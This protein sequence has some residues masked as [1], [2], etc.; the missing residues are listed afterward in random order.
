MT[1]QNF[2]E[3][4]KCRK[5]LKV[6]KTFGIIE[7]MGNLDKGLRCVSDM[8]EENFEKLVKLV[9]D[10]DGFVSIRELNAIIYLN[11]KF[12]K[13]F[14][15]DIDDFDFHSGDGGDNREIEW[16][17]AALELD[18][19]LTT[20]ASVY[21]TEQG[22]MLSEELSDINF[23][24]FKNEMLGIERRLWP[25]A[26]L[27]LYTNDYYTSKQKEKRKE[28]S[29]YVLNKYG[30]SETDVTTVEHFLHRDTK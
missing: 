22:R 11:S 19:L 25:A 15:Y 8:G 16:D 28:I 3:K 6:L 12:K 29:R 7:R 1:A 21:I 13:D 20:K 17:I 26:A 2:E 27:Y 23:S 18:N 5:N 14:N 24:E 30:F 4:Q 10:F 9:D